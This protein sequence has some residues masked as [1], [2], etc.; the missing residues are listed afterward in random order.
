M[1]VTDAEITQLAAFKGLSEHDFIQQF[2]RLRAD[3]RGLRRHPGQAARAGQDAT[4]P[5]VA[6]RLGGAGRRA[7]DRPLALAALI[8]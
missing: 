4:V 5:V 2:M 7:Y 6:Q 1:R 3:R 8:A